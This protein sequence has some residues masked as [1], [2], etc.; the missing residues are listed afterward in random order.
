MVYMRRSIGGAYSGAL[1][2]VEVSWIRRSLDVI[3]LLCFDTLRV[4]RCRLGP[5]SPG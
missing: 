3:R 1:W 4:R 5:A 2:T